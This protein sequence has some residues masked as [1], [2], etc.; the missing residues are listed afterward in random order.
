MFAPLPSSIV[1][2]PLYEF[3]VLTGKSGMLKLQLASP[4]MIAG[5]VFCSRVRPLAENTV[6]WIATG[7]AELSLTV[8]DSPTAQSAAYSRLSSK[9]P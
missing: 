2:A 4:S 9:R 3:I 5:H 7:K 6:D 8:N 1:N